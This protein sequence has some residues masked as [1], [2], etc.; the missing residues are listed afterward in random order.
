MFA[1]KI[2]A[3]ALVGIAI[4][5]AT[6][7]PGHAMGHGGGFS[8]HRGGGPAP[9]GHF[10]GRRAFDGHRFDGHHFDH[11]FDHRFHGGVIVAP[12]FWPYYSYA[13]DPGYTY[14][15]PA[16]SYWYYCPSYGSYYPTVQSC[17]E[18]WVPVPG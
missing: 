7:A 11:R 12:F 16:P 10:Q 18:A 8:G 15:A 13:P 14:E 17:P 1:K 9:S 2:S 5:L 3:I 6:A 4:V